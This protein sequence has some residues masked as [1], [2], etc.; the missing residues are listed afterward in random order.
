V[1]KNGE[2][3]LVI[4]GKESLDYNGGMVPGMIS[5]ILG[6]NFINS[7]TSLTVDETAITAIREIDGGKETVSSLPLVD[8]KG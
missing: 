7:C 6:Y 8:K 5:G 2:Y 3:D 4:A 1:I